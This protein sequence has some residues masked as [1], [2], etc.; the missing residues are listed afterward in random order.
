MAFTVQV[1]DALVQ[2]EKEKK[3]KKNIK[4]NR[5]HDWS[6]RK[7]NFF[8]PL[9]V[10]ILLA[11][12]VLAGSEPGGVTTHPP[13]L[14]CSSQIRISFCFLALQLSRD[15]IMSVSNRSISRMLA[16]WMR[17]PHFGTKNTWQ[18]TSHRLGSTLKEEAYA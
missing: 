10:C 17:Q 3:K 13:T 1:Q 16:S 7:L 14:T 4:E 2:K 18:R 15:M 6:A 11:P 5:P 9:I 12:T 8:V